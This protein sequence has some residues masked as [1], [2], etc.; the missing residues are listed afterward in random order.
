MQDQ[1]GE[2]NNGFAGVDDLSV[3]DHI[4]TII[5]GAFIVALSLRNL[6]FIA[7]PHHH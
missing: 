3:S 5:W 6:P 1:W 7:E 4:R 2:R